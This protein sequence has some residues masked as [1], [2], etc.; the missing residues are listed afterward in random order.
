MR[1]VQKQRVIEEI[2]SVEAISHNTINAM[3]TVTTPL[4]VIVEMYCQG[5]EEHITVL[6]NLMK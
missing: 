1:E 2:A 6:R 5:L 4:N 3:F